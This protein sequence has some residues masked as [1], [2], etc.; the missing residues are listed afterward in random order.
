MRRRI[1]GAHCLRTSIHVGCTR[2]V[3]S[4]LMPILKGKYNHRKVY[5]PPGTKYAE[6]NERWPLL[7]RPFPA[8]NYLAV[9]MATRW[10]IEAFIA[11]FGRL[12]DYERMVAEVT[13][14]SFGVHVVVMEIKEPA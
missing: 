12:P 10:A 1:F 14:D 7:A 11:E 3:G 13:C 9:E 6:A 8:A 2:L 4:I 5:R